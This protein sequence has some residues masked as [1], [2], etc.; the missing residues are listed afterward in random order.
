MI[1]QQTNARSV[2]VI[3]FSWTTLFFGFFPALF[4]GH[5]GAALLMFILPFVTLGIS[6]LIFPFFY[7]KWHWNWLSHKGFAPMGNGP[8]SF[9]IVN[10]VSPQFNSGR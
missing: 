3:G 6:W 4:R 2:G 8:T 5:I 9:S 10:N 7:N 1:N